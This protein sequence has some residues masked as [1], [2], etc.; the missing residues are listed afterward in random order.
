MIM[1]QKDDIEYTKEFVVPGKTPEDIWNLHLERYNFAS[2]FVKGKAVLDVACGVGYG[3]QILLDAG[4]ERVFGVDIN[5]NAV[6]YAKTH[7]TPEFKTMDA[8]K[9]DFPD[10]S[11]D[12]VVSFSTIEHLINWLD[13]LKE[14]KR[15]LKKDGLLMI[16]ISN[17]K[18]SLSKYRFHLTKFK[19]EDFLS[20]LQSNFMDIDVFSQGTWFFSFPGRGLIENILG[21]KRDISSIHEFVKSRKDPYEL[22]Y[23]CKEAIK[24]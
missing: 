24:K 2:K 22:I 17:K 19:K 18:F 12:V 7:Y 9:M 21:V 23:K 13:F 1:L 14:V 10:E 6:E 16:S 4:A 15:V 11:F 8:T 20:I 3:S 5:E